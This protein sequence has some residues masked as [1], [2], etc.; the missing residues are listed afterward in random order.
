MKIDNPPNAKSDPPG[1]SQPA[2]S[3][4]S[5]QPTAPT[6]DRTDEAL[7]STAI[8]VPDEDP[9]RA[10]APG[11]APPDLAQPP[12]TTGGPAF[13]ANT[14]TTPDPSPAPEGQGT[15][16]PTAAAT[17]SLSRRSPSEAE[18]EVAPSLA[19]PPASR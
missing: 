18:R 2:R 14:P 17:Q 5:P 6:R 3:A 4:D 16:P 12:H 11:G 9:S 7:D 1:P 19:F 13:P 10:P 15:V 8:V